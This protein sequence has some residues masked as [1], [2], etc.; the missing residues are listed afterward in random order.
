MTFCRAVSQGSN[1]ANWNTMPRSKPQP[2]TSLPS[3]T[4]L[5]P[6]A[7]SSPMA[8]RSAVVLPQPEGPIRATI[9]PSWTVKL[10]RSSACT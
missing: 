2:V 9:S 5:P 6:E 10:T 8:M 7:V 4:T 3:T 1:S